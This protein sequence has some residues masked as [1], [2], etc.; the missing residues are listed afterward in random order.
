MAVVV[1]NAFV[2]DKPPL[3]V[4]NIKNAAEIDDE[5]GSQ[6]MTTKARTIDQALL[7]SG[8]TQSISSGFVDTDLVLAVTPQHVTL[9]WAGYPGNNPNKLS[10]ECLEKLKELYD[11]GKRNK[12]QTVGAERA[13]QIL[14]ETLLFDKWDKQLDLTV[15]KIKAFFQMTPAKMDDAI[16]ISALPAKDVEE[17][18]RSLINV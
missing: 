11:I 3:F 10:S 4:Q 16:Q 1:A 13:H 17:A 5:E 12:K 6:L 7:T 2:S 14:V 15:P 9:K 8:I 18:S